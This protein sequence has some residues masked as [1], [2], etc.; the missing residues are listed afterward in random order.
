MWPSRNSPACATSAEAVPL[1]A[2]VR[3]VEVGP[4][5]GLQNE[6]RALPAETRLAL[7][8]A[9]GRAGLRTIEAGSFVSSRWVPQMAG[10]DAVLSRLDLAGR[11]AY[12]VLVP[13]L[14]GYAAARAAGAREVAIFAAASESFSQRNIN[15]SIAESIER[16]HPI[17]EAAAADGVRLRGY[18]SCVLGCPYEGR[19]PV[20]QV[21]AVA[22]ALFALGCSEISLGDTIGVGT[23]LAARAMLRAVAGEIPMDALALHCHDTYG[24]ALANIFACLEEG[25]S[26]VDAAVGGLGGCP[27]AAGASGNVATEDLVTMLDGMGIETGV[28]RDALLAAAHIAAEALGHPPRSKFAAARGTMP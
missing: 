18:V 5:D 25:L 26:V 22:R 3:I 17:A 1:P 13:N 12:P 2:T 23:P 6:A 11:I 20:A 7:I 15:C 16:F 14:Q 19:V 21:V 9:L 28:S 4:R 10:T 24:M 8:A 27:Y